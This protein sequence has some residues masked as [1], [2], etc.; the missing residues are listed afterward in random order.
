MGTVGEGVD[1]GSVDGI[2]AV[3]VHT[4]LMCPWAYIQNEVL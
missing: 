4:D 3:D 1:V 2:D